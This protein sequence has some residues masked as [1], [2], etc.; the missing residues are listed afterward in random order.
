MLTDIQA[1]KAKGADKPYKL[2]DSGGLFLLVSTTGNR[3]WRLKYRFGQ[4]EKL[5]TFG[6]YPDVSLVRARELLRPVKLAEVRISARP[7]NAEP[8]RSPLDKA[9]ERFAGITKQIVDVRRVG[10]KELP[11]ELDALRPG[12]A[13]DLREAFGKSHQLTKETAEGRIAGAIA[14]MDRRDA[15]RATERAPAERPARERIRLAGETE[16]RADLFVSKWKKEAA[17]VK[18]A[19]TYAARD[20]AR[21]KLTE[22]A[23]SLH[24]DAQLESLLQ[25][26]RAQP[27]LDAMS[28]KTLSQDL[29]LSLGRGRGMGIGM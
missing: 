9:V 6:S 20:A 26:R 28:T 10:G 13:N 4:K 12:S 24:R 5:L 25:N 18:Q 15:A 21:A 22:M 19:P 11:H 27:G 14:A 16:K 23:K 1:K 3:S 2:S 8:L 29:Q 17:V 7:L